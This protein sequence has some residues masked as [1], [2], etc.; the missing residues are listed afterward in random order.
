MKNTPNINLIEKKLE[1][2]LSDEIDSAKNNLIFTTDDGYSVFDI[3][4]LV[5]R[6]TEIEIS[7]HHS[8]VGVFS[9]TKNIVPFYLKKLMSFEFLNRF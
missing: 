6:G 8:V 9:S 2:I 1:N 3:Y 5:K 4:K 7:K